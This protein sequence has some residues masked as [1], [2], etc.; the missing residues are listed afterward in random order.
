MA[1]AQR[2]EEI[3][4]LASIINEKGIILGATQWNQISA[5]VSHYNSTVESG[6]DF[7]L[8]SMFNRNCSRCEKKHVDC[9]DGGFHS[10]CMK[11]KGVIEDTVELFSVNC[12]L[13]P[14]VNQ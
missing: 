13:V 3:K 12:A 9:T 10:Y 14:V 1:R 11:D 8:C 5:E 2:E 7:M 4:K 6:Q